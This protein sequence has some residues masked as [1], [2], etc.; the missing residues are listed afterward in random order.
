VRSSCWRHDEPARIE[1]ACRTTGHD[2]IVSAPF[3][4]AAHALPDGV[5]AESLGRLKLRGKE[6]EIELFALTRA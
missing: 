2:Y 5:R 3:V 4:R 6:D 1:E